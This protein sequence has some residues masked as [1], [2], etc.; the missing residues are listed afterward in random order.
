MKDKNYD[1]TRRV[2]YRCLHCGA[3]VSTDVRISNLQSLGSVI[4]LLYALII[5]SR[6]KLLTFTSWQNLFSSNVTYR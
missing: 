2:L 1:C 4:D 5:K 6:M 3:H